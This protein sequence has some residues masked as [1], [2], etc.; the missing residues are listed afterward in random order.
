MPPSGRNF[1]AKSVAVVRKESGKD[2]SKNLGFTFTSLLKLDSSKNFID[3]SYYRN[4]P[5]IDAAFVSSTM[6]LVADFVHGKLKEQV[7][8]PSG[9]S[10]SVI[11]I[12]EATVQLR[13]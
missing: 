5:I 12:V 1:E 8:A 11:L 9:I 10:R 4:S 6:R 2:S 3:Y 7:L 13:S